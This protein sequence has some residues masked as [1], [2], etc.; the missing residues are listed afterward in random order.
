[1]ADLLGDLDAAPRPI[2]PP[3]KK[4]KAVPSSAQF[5]GSGSLNGLRSSHA[6]SS[7][8]LMSSD[9]V[10]G[11]ESSQY[12]GDTGPSSDGLFDVDADTSRTSKKARVSGA[13]DKLDSLA[14][15]LD[16][17]NDDFNNTFD[18]DDMAMELFPEM[19]E[20]D[21]KAAGAAKAGAED[22]EDDEMQ[23]KQVKKAKSGGKRQQLV[24]ST[25]MKVKPPSEPV[26]KAQELDEYKPA[27]LD[28]KPVT[29]LQDKKKDRGMDWQLAA[30][31]V[32]L[33]GD[34]IGDAPIAGSEDVDIFSAAPTARSTKKIKAPSAGGGS[35]KTA[36]VQALEED[37]SVRFYWLDY[38]E[39]NGVL[40]FIG[41]VFDKE[42]KK[43]VS[44]CVT[45][46]GI[47]RNLFVL[48][49]QSMSDGRSTISRLTQGAAADDRASPHRVR[50]RARPPF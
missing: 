12:A 16:L 2:S 29:T 50:Q 41:K 42:T 30:A 39:T 37:G 9:P 45:V 19:R 21:K 35:L 49:R 38:V 47:D 13:E 23:V 26:V 18:G 15:D 7:S 5:S 14:L 11:P 48:P 22:D 8:S 36:K 34:E 20:K 32:T 24:N 27:S 33:E 3:L 17:D 43:Y 6:A 46:E 44:S 1:M 4:R 10:T 28:I 25:S 31:Q 40:H